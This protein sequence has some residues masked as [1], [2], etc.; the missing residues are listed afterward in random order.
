MTP[1]PTVCCSHAPNPPASPRL[2]AAHTTLATPIIPR[3][4]PVEQTS[5]LDPST[6][7]PSGM[8]MLRKSVEKGIPMTVASTSNGNSAATNGN[9][10]QHTGRYSAMNVSP[11]KYRRNGSGSRIRFFL[12]AA[13]FGLLAAVYLYFDAKFYDRIIHSLPGSVGTPGDTGDIHPS[14]HRWGHGLRPGSVK[15][16]SVLGERNSGT[17]WVYE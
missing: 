10:H 3:S 11:S 14:A 2:G 7:H 8:G 15:S 16:I 6:F 17:T 4:A 1:N 12:C 9:G 13:S 5:F